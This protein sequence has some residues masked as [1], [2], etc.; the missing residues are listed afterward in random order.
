MFMT[1]REIRQQ[2]QAQDIDRE[3]TGQG[4]TKHDTDDELFERKY[5]DAGLSSPF[6]PSSLK[7]SL[8][9]HGVEKPILLQADHNRTGWHGKPEI[10]NGH[11]RV[12]VMGV[13]RP[14]DLLP[15]EHVDFAQGDHRAEGNG[16]S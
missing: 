15:V 13:H 3:W 6:A 7:D 9:Q 2:Y 5:E 11:H 4:D 8:L 16:K 1:A 10:I 12:A 14:D